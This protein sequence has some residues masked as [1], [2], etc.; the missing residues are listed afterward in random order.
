VKPI[1]NHLNE[2]R[3]ALTLLRLPFSI[4]LLPVFLFA[5]VFCNTF[6]NEYTYE[7]TDAIGLFLILHLLIYPASNGYNSYYDKDTESIGGLAAPPLPNKKLLYLVNALD[8][9]AVVL[10]SF[11]SFTTLLWTLGYIA[12]SR[13][14]SG[15]PR[16]KKYPILSTLLVTGFQ[17]AGVYFLTL[18]GLG[19]N[20]PFTFEAILPAFGSTFFLMGAYP[21]TQIYQHKPDAERGDLTL[22]RMLGINGT[23]QFSAISFVIGGAVIN[24]SLYTQLGILPT[25]IFGL[26]T[27]IPLF[28]F[29][30]WWVECTKDANEANFKNTMRMNLFS[31]GSLTVAYLII[32]TIYSL[33]YSINLDSLKYLD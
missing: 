32:L 18:S 20:I 12:A 2:W 19:I 1:N 3:N 21:L 14:Y 6:S 26:A 25:I 31:S 28:Y 11:Y 17:G 24:Y 7:T 29:I 27:S 33:V 22:S 30:G 8:V 23:F 16:L 9:T 4:F 10:T 5:L 15:P 13:A